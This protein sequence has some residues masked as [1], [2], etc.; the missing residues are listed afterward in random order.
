MFKVS[1]S[2]NKNDFALPSFCLK[3]NK[4]LDLLWTLNM[5]MPTGQANSTIPKTLK[6]INMS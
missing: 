5:F 4:I 2:D 3:L 6:K 1:M